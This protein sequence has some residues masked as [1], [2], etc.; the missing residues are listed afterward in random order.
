M[1]SSCLVSDAP[2]ALDDGGL[3]TLQ[4]GDKPLR[5]WRSLSL[6]WRTSRTTRPTGWCLSKSSLLRGAVYQARKA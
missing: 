3:L 1:L 5:P 4:A 2:Q 6:P